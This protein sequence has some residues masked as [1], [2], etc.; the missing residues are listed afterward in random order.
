MKLERDGENSYGDIG[1][2]QIGNVHIGHSPHPSGDDD[3]V[4]NQG[5]AH[6]SR[7]TN[8]AIE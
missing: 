6:K 1:K 5:I 3:N 7:K 4:N 2:G 8:D